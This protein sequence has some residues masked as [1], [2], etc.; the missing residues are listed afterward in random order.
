MLPRAR[1]LAA[2]AARAPAP[3]SSSAMIADDSYPALS[4]QPRMPAVPTA[5]PVFAPRVG[6][7][8]RG[9]SGM[10]SRQVPAASLSSKQW[11][12]LLKHICQSFLTRL[13]VPDCGEGPGSWRLRRRNSRPL[14]LRSQERRCLGRQFHTSACVGTD[15]SH[16]SKPFPRAIIDRWPGVSSDKALSQRMGCISRERP[17]LSQSIWDRQSSEPGSSPLQR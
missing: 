13:S 16:A 9:S 2:L 14:D 3:V 8:L 5:S 15:N 6:D 10:W 1:L 17:A 12:L 7:A 4:R 11:M